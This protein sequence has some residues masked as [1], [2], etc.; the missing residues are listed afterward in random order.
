MALH[1]PTVITRQMVLSELI[2]AGINKDIADDLSYRYYKNELTPVLIKILLMIC[3]T[4]TI[5]M[6]LLTKILNT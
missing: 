6:S 4:D 5:K 1:Q 2:K 3:L